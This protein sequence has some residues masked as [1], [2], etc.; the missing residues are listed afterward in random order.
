MNNTDNTK[1]RGKAANILLVVLL[2]TLSM[3]GPVTIDMFLSSIPNIARGLD[4]TA[5]AVTVSLFSILLGNAVGFLIHG[6]VADRYGRKPA[7]IAMLILYV[8]TAVAAAFSPTVETLIIWRFVQGIAQAG[9]RVLAVAVARDLFDREHLG[10]AMADIM[11]VTAISTVILPVLGGQIAQHLPWQAS[12]GAMAVFGTVVALAF[13]FFFKESISETN[14]LALKLNYLFPN[15]IMIGRN[16]IFLRYVF[17]GAF[18][19]VGFIAF[20]TTSSAVL[21]GAFGVRPDVYG[22]LFATAALFFLFGTLTAGRLALRLGSTRSI[23]IGLS[24]FLVGGLLLFLLAILDIRT[25]WAVVI[26]SSIYVVGLGF[27]MAQ[28]NAQAMQPFGAVAGAA[29]SLMGLIQSIMAAAVA[30]VLSQ[31]VQ[32]TALPMGITMAFAAIASTTIFV[33]FIARNPSD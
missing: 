1:P 17:C 33:V 5:E 16:T 13:F 2:G 18:G 14:P 25:S 27:T 20:M 23:A 4:T 3:M 6:P 15:F 26:P 22:V 29:S 21:I 31:F 7:I 12:F 28:T 8:I 24:F 19:M 10:K 32:D 30:I 9:G 11:F